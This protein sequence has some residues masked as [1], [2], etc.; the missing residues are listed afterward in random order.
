MD[1]PPGNKEDVVSKQLS[2]PFLVGTMVDAAAPHL[3]TLDAGAALKSALAVATKCGLKSADSAK[4]SKLIL[5]TE[6]TLVERFVDTE[7]D[8]VLQVCGLE[9]LRTAMIHMNSHYVEGMTMSSHPGLSQREVEAAMKKFY[10]SLF[11]PPIPTFEDTIKDAEL[12]KIARSKTAERVLD[13]YRELYELISNSGK[14][15]YGDLSFLGHDPDQVKTL[16]LL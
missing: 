15:G 13:V 5:E 1:S 11:S 3:K 14:G 6:K 7:T 10:S 4:W 12:R 8:E 2:L 16:L 9:G